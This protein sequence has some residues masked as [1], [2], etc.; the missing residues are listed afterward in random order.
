[1]E[2]LIAEFAY[3]PENFLR[4][5]TFAAPVSFITITQLA[6]LVRACGSTRGY[7][8]TMQTGFT[9][10]V[11]LDGRVTARIVDGAGFDSGDRH[12]GTS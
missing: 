5:L 10:D 8:C 4:E 3:Q 9:D 12:G 1:M 7:N 2:W 6:S 11:N